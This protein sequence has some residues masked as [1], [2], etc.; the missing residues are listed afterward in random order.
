MKMCGLGRNPRAA[1]GFKIEPAEDKTSPAGLQLRW[2][3]VEAWRQW[4]RLKASDV[5]LKTSAGREIR[6]CCITQPDPAQRALPDRMGLVIPERLGRPSWV[7][8]PKL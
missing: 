6:P 5:I 7:R 3:R 2:W 1:G 8:T 4:T